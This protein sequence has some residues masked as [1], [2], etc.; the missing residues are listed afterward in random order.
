MNA[1]FL[2]LL[3]G[4]LAGLLTSYTDLKTGFIFDN[5]VFPLLALIE[6][7]KG[8]EEEEEVP[9]NPILTRIPVPAVEVGILLY[10]YLGIRSGDVLLAL[11]G[12]IGFFVGLILGLILY[13]AGAWA[14]GDVLVL[15]GFSALLPYPLHYAGVVAP[16]EVRY[17]LY[18]IAILFNSILAVFPFLFVYALGVLIA[19]RKTEKLK[20]VL[21]EKANLSVEVALWLMAGIGVSVLLQKAGMSVP[22]PVRYLITVVLL[23]AFGKYRRV[24]DALGLV[25][26]AYLTYLI[27]ADAVYSFLK[28]LVVLYL[29]KVFF[30]IVKVLREEA[31]VEEV[32]VEELRE[33][34]ILGETIYL[35]NG[36]VKRDRSGFLELLS[37]ALKEGNLGALTSPAGE[38]VIASP[39]AEGLSREQIERL[40]KLV[41]EGK[42]E[43][44]FLRKKAMPFAPSIFIGFLIAF[45]WGDVFW[46]LVL[47][48]AGL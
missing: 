29:F 4:S 34:D 35:E 27:G 24:G 26:F 17:P 19:R 32:T 44:R 37:R 6:R 33:W 46:W 42:I 1:D 16:Y 5:H 3:V 45:F 14:S 39:T 10:L 8:L 13:Y 41:E 11:A 28:L 20:Q 9:L 43:N 15:A 40:R 30:S 18:P 38:E 31:L 47:K 12:I 22:S 2:V 23:I 21:F 25:S 36:E 7:L 48:T